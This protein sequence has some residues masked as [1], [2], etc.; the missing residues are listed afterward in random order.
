MKLQK[1]QIQFLLI[2]LILAMLYS[3]IQVYSANKEDSGNAYEGII[4]F[5]VIA[6]SDSSEDQQ[7]KL[8]VRDGVL[9]NIHEEMVKETMMQDD[10]STPVATLSL[11]ESREYLCSRTDEISKLAEKIIQNEGYDYSVK[12]EL[13]MCWIP[14]KDYGDFTLPAGTYEALN[15]TI[16]EGAGQ[17]WWC[18]LFPPLCLIDMEAQQEGLSASEAAIAATHSKDAIDLAGFEKTTPA[19]IKLKSKTAE[20]LKHIK[21]R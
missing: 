14:E 20:I 11:E 13:G 2:L 10:G 21:S 6:N 15:I 4:R 19:P 18:V 1:R 16:G 8:K 17:N 9:E 7:L 5:H 3:G 12:T